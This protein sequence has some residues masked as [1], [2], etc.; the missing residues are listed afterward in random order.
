MQRSP[1]QH[2]SGFTLFEA[3]LA[4]VI[5]AMAI[6]AIIVPFTAGAQNEQADARRTLATSLAQEMMEE[7]LSRPFEDPQ[8]SSEPGPEPE[9]VSRDQFDNIDDYDGYF[10]A[11]GEVVN[12]DGQ[13]V[14]DPAAVGLSRQVSAT[15]VYV[16]GQ[17][18]SEPPT[19]IRVKVEVHYRG[20]AVVTL[21]RLVFKTS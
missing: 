11:V 1:L 13:V 17:D 15:Y 16:S 8:G 10:E 18:T 12:M 14:D 7:V 6:A 9:E 5:L 19:F 20:Q 2:G 4:A 21:T 3:L